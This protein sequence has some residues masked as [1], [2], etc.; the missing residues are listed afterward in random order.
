MRKV[1]A[2]V[3]ITLDG[4]VENP[5]WT[6]PF[7]NDEAAKFA[8]AQLF[9]ADALLLGRVTYQGFVQAW[10]SMTDE[11]GFADKMN[12]MPKYVATTTLETPEWNATFLGGDVPAAVAELKQ[13]DGGDLLIYGSGDLVNT[14]LECDLIDELRL[15]AHP[16]IEGTGKRL[17]TE[18]SPKKTLRPIGTTTFSTGAQVHAYAPARPAGQ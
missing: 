14:L 1:I 16:V 10:P 5:A 13:Q 2:S 17:F 8:Q 11:D 4:V 6:A 3:Y 15:W 9:A 18:R 7:F 12:S